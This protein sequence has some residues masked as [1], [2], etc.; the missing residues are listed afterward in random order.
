MYSGP[1]AEDM[2]Q[3]HQVAQHLADLLAVLLLAVKRKDADLQGRRAFA[4]NL[5][6]HMMRDVQAV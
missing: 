6:S 2:Q 4:E 3:T 1:V 5:I